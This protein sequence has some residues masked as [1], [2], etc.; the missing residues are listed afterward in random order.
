LDTLEATLLEIIVSTFGSA[1][2]IL[3]VAW[4][5][6]TWLKER[7]TASV[8]LETEQKLATLKSELEAANQRIRDLASVGSAVNSQ[9]ESS[10]L[11]HRIAAVQK[12]WESVQSWQQVSAATMMVSVLSDDWIKKN[13]SHPGTK[14]T[15]EQILKNVDH[16]GFMKKQNETELV[17]P[18]LSEPAWALFSA[19]H[20]FLS[21]RL[22]K[23]ILLTLSGIDHAEVL[24][25][26]SERNLVAKSAPAEIVAAYD[27]SPYAATEPY[28]R[29]LRE[30]MLAEFR[31]F[32]SGHRA[33]NQAVRDAAEILHAAEDLAAKSSANSPDAQKRKTA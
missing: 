19:Y 8:R 30:K 15:F 18:F 21:A 33:G 3:V 13:A 2:L 12:V 17:R 24:S 11:E 20:S 27:E 25:Q 31:E 22:T 4:L 14:S 7:L 1:S 26:F 6:R 10:L 29:F 23:A 28:L 5:G 16:L 32:L 9:V